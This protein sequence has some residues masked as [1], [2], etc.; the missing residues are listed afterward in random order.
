MFFKSDQFSLLSGCL[1]GTILIFQSQWHQNRFLCSHCCP[2]QSVFT[3][4]I[5]QVPSSLFRDSPRPSSA[6]RRLHRHLACPQDLRMVC[7][8]HLFISFRLPP[9]TLLFLQIF[10][11]SF[12]FISWRL[13]TLQYCSG[14]CHTLT[15]ISHGFTC[16][17]L[18]DSPLPPPSPS[19]PSGSSQCTSPEH[20]SHASNLGW[21]SV[22]PLIVYLFQCYS[23]KS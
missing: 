17:P 3:Q 16:V 10:F 2:Q 5:L 1:V 13:I 12:I 8:L 14:F 6:V 9:V 18:P 20:L 11:F 23:Y 15:W 19:H 7:T 4:K 21:R 22:S